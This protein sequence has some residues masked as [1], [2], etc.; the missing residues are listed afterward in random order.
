MNFFY[1]CYFIIFFW[2]F[3][4]FIFFKSAF[5]IYEINHVLSKKTKDI[6]G[7]YLWLIWLFPRRSCSL[8]PLQAQFHR[9]FSLQFHYYLNSVPTFLN[10]FFFLRFWLIDLLKYNKCKRVNYLGLHSIVL[11]KASHKTMIFNFSITPLIN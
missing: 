4:W 8:Y 3:L 6:V 2:F 5:Y 1:W 11:S 7:Q 10:L 9:N